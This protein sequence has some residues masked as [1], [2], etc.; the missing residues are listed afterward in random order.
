MAMPKRRDLALAMVFLAGCTGTYQRVSDPDRIPDDDGEMTAAHRAFEDDVVPILHDKCATCHSASASGSQPKFLGEGESSYYDQI[1]LYPSVTGDFDPG[2]A[3]VL[4]KIARGH[5]AVTYSEAEEAAI[6]EWLEAEALERGDGDDDG[7]V[8]RPPA[9]NALA[10]WAG[11]MRL[12]DWAAANM[13]RWADKE[14]EEDGPC[15][16]C[17]SDGLARFFAAPDSSE[18]FAMHRYELYI[19][20]FFT[21]KVDP[22][23]TQTVVP[24]LGKLR[25]MGSG[26][27]HPNYATD[28]EGDAEFASLAEFH[29][30][31][32]NRKASGQCGPAEFPA[33]PEI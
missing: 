7:E 20:G 30:L 17:H 3:G 31:T 5:Y 6:L 8:D 22:E 24:A 16:N 12:D 9:V 25:R 14:T 26:N 1:L 33:A 15:M 23:G 19:I 29:R 18:M 10:E 4:T 13:G 27:F 32:M 11:C 21:V 28:E 2:L